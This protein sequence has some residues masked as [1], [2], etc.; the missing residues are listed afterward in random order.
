M[1]RQELERLKSVAMA[2]LKLKKRMSAHQICTALGFGVRG[3]KLPADVV[4]VIEALDEEEAIVLPSEN[5]N[6]HT[7]ITLAGAKPRSYMFFQEWG[8]D[9]QVKV[10]K[11]DAA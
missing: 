7:I 4:A 2:H 5:L 8:I 3:K 6:K 10:R 1:N 9:G 11:E